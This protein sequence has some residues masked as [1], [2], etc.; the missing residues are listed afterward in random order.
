MPEGCG[1]QTFPALA[2]GEFKKPK[3]SQNCV[4]HLSAGLPQF[5]DHYNKKQNLLSFVRANL[6]FQTIN[7]YP[8]ALHG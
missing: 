8:Q 4:I 1:T 3:V 2:I 5:P 7:Y 6:M